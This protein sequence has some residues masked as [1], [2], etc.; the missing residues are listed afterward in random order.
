MKRKTIIYSIIAVL[1]LLFVASAIFNTRKAEGVRV[2]TT[3]VESRSIQE[4]VSASGKVFPQTEVKISSDVS[5]E[6]VELHVQEGDSVVTGQLLAKIDA[7]AYESQ[8]ARG[9][10][11]VNA[12]KAQEANAKAQIITLEAQR[13]QVKAQLKNARDIYTRNLQLRKEGVI[14]Q[15]DME[16]SQASLEALEANLKSAESNIAA[17]RESAKAAQFQIESSQATLNELKT[18]LRRTAIYAPMGGLVSL[19]NVEQ[20]ER[21]VGT[22]QMT[23]TEM[24]RIANLNVMELRV[25]VS[26]S[27]IPKIKLGD[28]A[29]VEIDAYLGRK[30]KGTVTQIANSSTNAATAERVLNSDQVT[31]F[32]VRI[33][34]D[35]ASYKDLLASG[36]GYPFRPGMSASADILTK[37]ADEVVSLPIQCV[38]TRENPEYKNDPSQ[39]ELLEVVFV[40]ESDTIRQLTVTTGLQDDSYIAVKGDIAVGQE[41]AKGPYTA[42][43]QALKPGTKVIVV[44]EEDFYN[45]EAGM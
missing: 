17:A 3:A 10:A 24:M 36:K 6:I 19:L 9:L 27:D 26:E 5:G 14:S 43:S 23:G 37:R 12:A 44:K 40:V 16:A 18:S 2:F 31:N 42:I 25:E 39:E 35:P 13:D 38:S 33:G 32:E 41:V 29:V 28:E 4:K 21:V 20:G 30:F 45:K 7:D 34:I 1:L 8:V 22:I 15:A 11:S